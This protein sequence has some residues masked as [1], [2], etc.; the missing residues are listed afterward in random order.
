MKKTALICLLLSSCH[1]HFDGTI[2]KRHTNYGLIPP[3]N[4]QIERFSGADLYLTKDSTNSSIVISANCEKVSQ[5]PLEALTA[6]LLA[7]FTDIKYLEQRKIPI[8]QR[9]GLLSSITAKLDGVERYIKIV[10]LKKNRCV[11]DMVLSS[12]TKID[13]S[14]ND[15]DE[16]INTF[17]ANADL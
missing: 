4:W 9:E 17:W 8:A 11:Y 7:G 1:S 15:F 16:M 5:S 3:K 2:K 10:V 6:Q 13:S 12:P 14:N